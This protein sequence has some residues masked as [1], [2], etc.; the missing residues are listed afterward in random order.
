[1]NIRPCCGGLKGQQPNS[2][3]QRLGFCMRVMAPPRR[4][5]SIL[6]PTIKLLPCQGA[7][8]FVAPSSP[9][10]CPG[11]MA[12]CPF[13]GAHSAIRLGDCDATEGMLL[14]IRLCIVLRQ[15]EMM[16]GR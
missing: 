3:R 10:C 6:L 13:S 5:I 15:I 2:P 7:V 1:M 12:Q 9:G 4:G 14:G 8:C 16:L 11:L